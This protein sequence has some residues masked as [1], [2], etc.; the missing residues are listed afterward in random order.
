MVNYC[1]RKEAKL[2]YRS[3]VAES[4]ID[5]LINARHKRKQKMQW[6]RVGAHDV[7]Q[8]RASIESNEWDDKWLDLVLPGEKEAA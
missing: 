4:H 3:Q 1:E 2:A 7:L 8:I 6:S 5:T